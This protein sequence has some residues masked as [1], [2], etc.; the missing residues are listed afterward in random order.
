MHDYIHVAD[1]ARANLMAMESDVS[2]ES[3]NVATG[4]STSL[5][6]LVRIIQAK[7]GTSLEPEYKTPEG[8]IRATVSSTLKFSNKKIQ[9]QLGWHPEVSLE[10]GI[11]RLIRWRDGEGKLAA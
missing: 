7:A 2:R 3:F 5:N 1:I 11:E 9:E 8:K 10:E 4:V 6:E